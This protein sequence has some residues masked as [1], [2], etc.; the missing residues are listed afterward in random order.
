MLAASLVVA[1]LVPWAVSADAPA[2]PRAMVELRE[3][4]ADYAFQGEFLGAFRVGRRGT[5]AYALQVVALGDGK[6]DGYVLRGGLPGWGW[7]GGPRVKLSGE[8]RD[9]RVALSGE[10]V[11]VE[12]TPTGARVAGIDGW[13][14]SLARFE[15][16]SPN[17]GLRPPPGAIV[18]FDGRDTGELNGVKITSEGLLEVGAITKRPVGDFRLHIEFRTPYMPHA[19]GQGRGNSGVYIQQRYEVQVLDSFGLPGEFNECGALYRQVPPALNMCLPP[20]VWQS[21]DIEFRAAR[22]DAEGKV[23]IAPAVITVNHNGV[24]VHDSH[25][26]ASKTGAGQPEGPTPRPILFQ[27]HSDPVRFRNVWLVDLTPPS[28][29]ELVAAAEAECG[30]CRPARRGLGHRCWRRR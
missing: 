25:P 27:N 29:A 13:I 16:T 30:S 20:L 2:K 28:G 6:F 22:F 15:R 10:G 5:V 23:K 19:R 4:D 9:D 14:V 8:R 12:V 26:I 11:N 3:V 18:L 24:A 1:A 21:Y 17:L 7:D